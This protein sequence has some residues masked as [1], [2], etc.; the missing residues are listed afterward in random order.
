MNQ[1]RLYSGGKCPNLLHDAFQQLSTEVSVDVYDTVMN[2][3]CLFDSIRIILGSV[4]VFHTVGYLRSVA[5]RAILNVHDEVTQS[6][7]H[8]WYCIFHDLISEQEPL[9]REYAFM[10]SVLGK[11]WPLKVQ[12]ISQISDAMMQPSLYWGEEHA[13]RLFEK[14]LLVRF[15]IFEVVDG[16]G[17]RL[18][19]PLDHGVQQSTHQPTHYLLLMLHN[20]HYQP[21]RI[22]GHMLYVPAQLPQCIQAAIQ[23]AVNKGG[24]MYNVS[25][26][27]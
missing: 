24:W 26:S 14:Q 6:A 17:V 25:V 9:A 5:A 27:Q 16:Q 21:L 13:L 7:L 11:P 20:R 2:G 3:D 12:D 23:I 10:N 4:G 1:L 18:H 15:L 19:A 22:Q 8:A